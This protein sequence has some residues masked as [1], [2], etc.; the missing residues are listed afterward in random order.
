MTQAED[1]GTQEHLVFH[2]SHVAEPIPLGLI[3]L[4]LQVFNG[5]CSTVIPNGDG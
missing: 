5:R 4:F 3:L 2:I 1:F